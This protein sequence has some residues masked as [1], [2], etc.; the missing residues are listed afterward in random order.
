MVTP[1]RRNRSKAPPAPPDGPYMEATDKWGRRHYFALSGGAIVWEDIFRDP[2]P[3][4]LWR[5]LTSRERQEMQAKGITNT[6]N[7]SLLNHFL[8]ESDPRRPALPMRES[9]DPE[10]PLRRVPAE[11]PSKDDYGPF[12]DLPGDQ[13][14][15]GDGDVSGG[16][17]D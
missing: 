1:E 5:R 12:G 16:T 17:G 3:D 15:W 11:G 2:C 10:T 6:Y 4:A 7:D 13:S 14:Q 9:T 8:L